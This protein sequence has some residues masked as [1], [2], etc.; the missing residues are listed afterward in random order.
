MYYTVFDVAGGE[1]C[2]LVAQAFLNPVPAGLD[3]FVIGGHDFSYP[4]YSNYISSTQGGTYHNENGKDIISGTVET[5]GAEAF[6][7]YTRPVAGVNGDKNYK[8]VQTSLGT[9]A[10]YYPLTVAWSDILK[11]ADKMK[12][13]GVPANMKYTHFCPCQGN[14]LRP[15]GLWKQEKLE[16]T[17]G[18]AVV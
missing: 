4:M 15:S 1:L 8:S 12:Q 9:L 13:A 14:P 16:N 7:S 18:A 2:S 6:T 5:G 10:E 17:H 11:N 3:M